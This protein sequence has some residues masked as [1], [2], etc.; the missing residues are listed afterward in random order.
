MTSAPD[1]SPWQPSAGQAGGV[2]VS[3]DEALTLVDLETFSR[4]VWVAN[5]GEGTVSR[6]DVDTG[7]E[8]GRY[9]ASLLPDHDPTE[10]DPSR[11]AID[12]GGNCWVANRYRDTRRPGAV[13]KIAARRRDCQDRDKNG[14]ID[15]SR[16]LNKDGV[17]DVTSA[18][19][20]GRDDECVLFTTQVGE[21]ASIARALAVAPDTSGRSPLGNAWVGLNY[22]ETNP[23][24]RSAVQIDGQTGTVLATYPLDLNP[25][26]ALAAGGQGK[27]WFT[28]TRWQAPQIGRPNRQLPDNP[29]AIQGID[30]RSGEV[31][32]RYE[33]QRAGAHCEGSYGLAV[34]PAGTIWV[35]GY[36][37]PYVFRFDPDNLHWDSVALD[38]GLGDTRGLAADRDGWIWVAR[39]QYCGQET[40]GIL[41]RFHSS[42]VDRIE[43]FF[44]PHGRETIGVDLDYLGRLWAVNRETDTVSRLDPATG[45]VEEFNTGPSPYSYSDFTGYSLSFQF[46]QGHYRATLRAC[47]LAQWHWARADVHLPPGTYASLRLRTAATPQDLHDAP[48]VGSWLLP[49]ANL[50]TP[51][52]RTVVGR[53]AEFEVTLMN[54][55][56]KGD[57]PVVRSLELAYSCPDELI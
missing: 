54:R 39:S 57:H 22:G 31:G 33:V 34:D 46:P 3:D 14:Q 53:L 19:Y 8:V 9:P 18:E 41:T 35:S 2:T 27:V 23:E 48:W 1:W 10:A 16:D 56:G 24:L 17:I 30:F 45:L 42:G 40:C 36:V 50:S 5:T 26:G 11:T 25:Y 32:P 44:L 20:W 28:N 38:P 55:T 51:S 29:P 37:C 15:T 13:T 6:L 49:R 7:R 52:R 12:F 43:N 4:S 47:P 21:G